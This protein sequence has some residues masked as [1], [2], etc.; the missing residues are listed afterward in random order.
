MV[1]LYDGRKVR[2]SGISGEVVIPPVERRKNGQKTKYEPT[3]QLYR[4]PHV[5][6]FKSMR[7]RFMLCTVHIAYGRG[8]AND[9]QRE[10]EISL[11]A[12]FLAKRAADKNAWT[13]NLIL[14]G[15]FNIFSRTDTT[16]QA[17]LDAGFEVPAPLRSLP[18]NANRNRYYDQ[19]AFF[20]NGSIKPTSPTPEVDPR[21]QEPGTRNQ[22][23]GTRAASRRGAAQRRA[24]RRRAKLLSKRVQKRS[25][26][27]L[28][29]SDRRIV[30]HHQP[31]PAPDRARQDQLL[32]HVLAHPPDERSSTDVGRG[33]GG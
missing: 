6:G 24:P 13:R 14:L 26:R 2:F 18:S 27:R 23:P 29:R 32:P 9:P 11:I 5:C 12:E 10:Q 4:T 3:R 8:R 15:D 19:I 31:R 20:K 25:A 7:K 16:L 22:E 33:G 1:F 17:L 30:Q 28:R 21:N